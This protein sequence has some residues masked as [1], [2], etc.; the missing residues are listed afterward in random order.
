MNSEFDCGI[1]AESLNKVNR[2]GSSNTTRRDRPTSHYSSVGIRIG[3]RPK[4]Q[5][6]RVTV[7]RDEA[8]ANRVSQCRQKPRPSRVGTP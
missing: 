4:V 8:G 7:S 1:R 6:N 5:A 2:G 3:V